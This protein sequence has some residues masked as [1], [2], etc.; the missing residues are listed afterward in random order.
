[1]ILKTE[2]YEHQKKAVEK[3]RHVKVGALY[4]E[5][6]T[7]KTRTA[8]ELVALRLN[9][10]KIDQVLWLCPCSVIYNLKLD[11]IKHCGEDALNNIKIM[12]IESLSQS[13]RIN[14]EAYRYVTKQRTF[15]IVD[16]SNLVKNPNALR[17]KNIDRLAS[18]CQY[19]LILNGTPITKCEKDL[20]S[21]WHILDWRILGY[22]TFWSFAANHLEYDDRIKG[23]VVRVL[24]VDYLTKKIAPYTYQ[25]K[26]DECLDLPEKTYE[27]VY[28][29]LTKEQYQHYNMIAEEFI[30][31]IYQ[32]QA[33]EKNNSAYI[34]KYFTALQ[35]ITSGLYI[36][37]TA[38]EKITSRPFF[39]N[40]IDNPRV[41][42]LLEIL[43]ELSGKV[44]IW[45]KYT[46]E[47]ETLHQLIPNSLCIYGN[48]NLNQRNKNIQEFK[49][50]SCDILIANKSCG[51]Y[52]NNLQFCNYAIYYSNDWDW[53]T[54]IQSEDRIH[55]IGQNK[56]VH[57]I[58][59][60]SICTIEE[61]I[62]SSLNKKENLVSQFQWEIRNKLDSKKVL[63]GL[64]A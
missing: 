36:T 3:L 19:K 37:S 33:E 15:L 35:D 10:D 7:G 11:I 55:R 24:N 38:S 6:G 23:R 50:G 56:N 44:I 41:S 26:K 8:L 57:I 20:Y 12:G 9:A 47:I 1:M 58:D 22:Q 49:N 43:A 31:M 13:L 25:I 63:E 62:L 60:I 30:N 42:K 52:G 32:L 61:R 51:G 54:R 21:Q 53:A 46:H 5:M 39:E 16:E 18:K 4:M 2:L 48:L 28:F 27:T 14:C 59:L 34:Y 17:T 29:Y 40:P 45:C 64:Y